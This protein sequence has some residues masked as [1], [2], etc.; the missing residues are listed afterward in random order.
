M[1]KLFK[2]VNMYNEIDDKLNLINFKTNNHHVRDT[3]LFYIL[4]NA[5]YVI[6]SSKHYFIEWQRC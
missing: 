6:L 4:N 5:S 1:S 2:T 3:S